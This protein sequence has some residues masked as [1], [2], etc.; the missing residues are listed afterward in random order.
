MSIFNSNDYARGHADGFAAGQA[1]KDKDYGRMGLSAKFVLYGP[2]ALNTYTQGYNAGYYLGISVR[3]LGKCAQENMSAPEKQQMKNTNG[4]S[5]NNYHIAMQIGID[6]QLDL[7][8]QMKSFLNNINSQF[9]EMMQVQTNFL[10]GL[11]SEG[12]DLKILDRCQDYLSEK[13]DS[14]NK[15]IAII[16]D[17]EVPYI[18]QIIR[19]LEETPR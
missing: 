17:E 1:G 16:S 10:N 2:K 14:L 12:L 4:V 9:E 6:G 19:H 3:A 18:E 13:R 5:F 8:E 11:E 15:V 7:L